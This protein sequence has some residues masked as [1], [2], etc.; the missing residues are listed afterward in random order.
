[1]KKHF[2][3]SLIF[4][5]I[6]ALIMLPQ[7]VQHSI[8]LGGDSLFHFNRFFDAEQQISHGNIQYFMSVYGFSK[9]GRIVNALYGPYIAY[10]NGFILYI[11]KSWFLYQIF[12]GIFVLF[13]AGISMYYLLMNNK[14]NYIYAVFI[15]SM[16]MMTYGV[17][18]WITE[19]SF[20]SWGAIIVPLGLA[21]ATRL[22][23]NRQKPIN[24][25]EM[26]F[27]TS[28]FIETHILSAILLI[29]VYI[30]FGIISIFVVTS[31][32]KLFVNLITSIGIT[33]VLTSNIWLAL[34]EIYRDNKILA[35]FENLIPFQNGIINFMHDG[36]LLLIFSIIFIFQIG[37]MFF[38][39]THVSFENLVVTIVGGT[40][41]FLTLPVIPWNYLFSHIPFISIIQY[42]FRL[43]PFS[44]GLLLIGFALTL[45]NLN[46]NLFNLKNNALNRKLVNNVIKLV[47]FITVFLTVMV[48]Q[49]NVYNVSAQWKSAT[50]IIHNKHSVEYTENGEQLRQRFYSKDLGNAL[51]YIWKPTP[52]YLPIKNNAENLHPY[53]RYDNE[54]VKNSNN[55]KEANQ[56]GLQVKWV[57]TTNSYHNIGVV[58]Y[59]D[60]TILINGHKPKR[61]EY[62]TTDLGTVMVK[63][64]MGQNIV[65]I[66]YK[67]RFLTTNMLLVNLFSWIAFL[68]ISLF[69]ILKRFKKKES[70]WF[71]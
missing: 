11:L 22:I 47:I 50:N 19:Q 33:M 25:I 39:I 17:I 61:G 27:V 28:L 24:I 20:L 71:H 26:S 40:L 6:A 35:P 60:S 62:Y 45:T 34:F 32:K 69:V 8:I 65:N 57:S 41:F 67:P 46:H 14:I 48:V 36:R 56:K 2:R 18:T 43:L 38:K 66:S 7:L 12:T 10:F 13:I 21:V 68:A 9:S 4:L 5:L 15:S 55:K 58:K 70:R 29:F 59:Y 42:P 49:N 37:T 31:K 64:R 54:I 30:I 23:R 51:N 16:Y 1:M 52:D 53:Y 44:E 3:A 63:S